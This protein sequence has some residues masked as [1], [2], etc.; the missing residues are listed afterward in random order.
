MALIHEESNSDFF[1]KKVETAE[2]RTVPRT[3]VKRQG[4]D[5]IASQEERETI[6]YPHIS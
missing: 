1:I 2:S 4:G 6:I 3:S 5:M